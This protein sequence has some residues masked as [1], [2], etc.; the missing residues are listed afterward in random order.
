MLDYF[1]TNCDN[2]PNLEG[3]CHKYNALL[4]NYKLF[5]ATTNNDS[6]ENKSV[7]RKIKHKNE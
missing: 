6:I 7:I 2:C 1:P 4:R 5:F 3:K